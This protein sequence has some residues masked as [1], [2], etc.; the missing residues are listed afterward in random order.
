MTNIKKID[1][2]IYPEPTNI[3]VRYGGGYKRIYIFKQKKK[4]T[5]VKKT[6]K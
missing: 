3:I 2:A 6:K 4:E 5:R 1:S